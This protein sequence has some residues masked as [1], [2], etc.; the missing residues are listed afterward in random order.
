MFMSFIPRSE[1]FLTK[2]II[3]IKTFLVLPKSMRKVHLNSWKCLKF[4]ISH[5]WFKL[6]SVR[7]L[8][9]GDGCYPVNQMRAFKEKQCFVGN[10]F[11]LSS[12]VV[13]DEIIY[14][15]PSTTCLWWKPL[16]ELWI[17][18]N[19]FFSSSRLF[20]G[21][22]SLQISVVGNCQCVWLSRAGHPQLR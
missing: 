20:L 15:S 3:F 17:S 5:F 12:G 10:L 9:R 19:C 18:L 8:F 14:H 7:I 1:S 6:S 22:A 11:E 2:H 21:S 13:Q 4:R 16:Q